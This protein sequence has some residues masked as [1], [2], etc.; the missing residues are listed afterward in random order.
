MHWFRKAQYAAALFA[1]LL[2]GIG[3][4][5][6]AGDHSARYVVSVYLML[7]VAVALTGVIAWAEHSMPGWLS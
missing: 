5:T 6:R 4:A 3:F 7:A 2:T 1:F